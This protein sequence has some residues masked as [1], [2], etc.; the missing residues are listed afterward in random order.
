MNMAATNDPLAQLY[1]IEGL[2]A[3]SWW[4]P[5]L[6]WWIIAILMLLILIVLSILYWRKRCFEMSWRYMALKQLTE[7]T[8]FE[9]VQVQ[10]IALSELIRRIAI[11]QY[12]R[13]ECAG[14]VGRQWLNWLSAHDPEKFDWQ[15]KADWLVNVPYAPFSHIEPSISKAHV[16]AVVQA[17]KRWIK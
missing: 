7:I 17:I 11:R 15:N 2:D 4:P 6:G 16:E 12:S 14:L 9:S 1:D 5:A 13:K 8:Q 3:I 10:A